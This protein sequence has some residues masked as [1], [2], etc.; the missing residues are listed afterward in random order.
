[1]P[2]NSKNIFC[3]FDAAGSLKCLRYQAIPVERSLMSFLKASSSFQAQGR[4]TA[5]QP[6][7]GKDGSFAAA[8]SPTKTFQLLLKLKV[9]R[10]ACTATARHRQ[11]S[12]SSK[13]IDLFTTDVYL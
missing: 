6:A 13:A 5:F 10:C 2:S 11:A 1:M 7:S 9:D 12:A 3:A 8:V 4:V